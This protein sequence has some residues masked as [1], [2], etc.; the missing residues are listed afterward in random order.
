MKQK[1]NTVGFHFV[2]TDAVYCIDPVIAMET[3]TPFTLENLPWDEPGLV[4]LF[5]LV[6]I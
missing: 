2:V 5:T 6:M 4:N 1:E 3:Y